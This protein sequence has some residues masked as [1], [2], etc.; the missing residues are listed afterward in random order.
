MKYVTHT[1][2]LETTEPVH[3]VDITEEVKKA[4]TASC[5]KQG[6]MTIISQ[7]TTAFVNIN[8]YE[9]R[10]M[11][12]MVTFLKR[13]VPRDGNYAHNIAPIDGR[14]NAHSHLMGLFMNSSETIPF[15]QTG[16]M[17][18]QWQS[19]FFIELDGPRPKRSILLHMAG[20]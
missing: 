2:N 10:L 4:L 14:D 18:G 12:D 6:Q 20:E 5:L 3:I 16:L 9:P 15:N 17:L 8:E 19:I 11:D 7:H 13:Q 1:I